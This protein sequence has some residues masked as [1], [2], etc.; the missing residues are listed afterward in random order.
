MK[1]IVVLT[2]AGMSVESGLKTFRDADGLWENYPVQDVATHDGWLR[3]PTLVTNFYNMLRRKCLDTQP[4]EG[5][6]LVAQLEE[7]YDVTVVTQN[8]DN[9]HE[10]AGSTHVVHLHGELMKVCSSIDPYD[11]RYIQTLT[12]D[13]PE[14]VPG[15]KAGDGSLL[16]PHIVFFQEAV[17]MIETAVSECMKADIFI[18][19]GTSLV[20]YPAAGLVNYVPENAPIYL[21]DPGIVNQGPHRGRGGCLRTASRVSEKGTAPGQAR[22][23]LAAHVMGLGGYASFCRVPMR[24]S[25]TLTT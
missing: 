22:E 16:R 1:K 8:V 14:V 5:H 6:R 7:K 13:N 17:P 11:P 9:L 15:T 24:A 12:R 4:N 25:T 10:M 19:I 2:G 23:V 3:D 21:I 20:V 18:I